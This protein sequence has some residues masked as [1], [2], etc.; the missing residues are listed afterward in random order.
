MNSPYPDNVP[1]APEHE[2]ERPVAPPESAP[3][4]H[5]PAF[6]SRPEFE[7]QPF[8]DHGSPPDSP[9]PFRGIDLAYLILFYF[10]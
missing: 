3:A 9:T 6:I 10:L 5:V 4:E 1:A 2:Q 8:Q 7:A